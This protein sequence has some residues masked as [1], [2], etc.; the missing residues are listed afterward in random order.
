MAKATPLVLIILDGWGISNRRED[1]AIALAR[2]LY[3]ESLIK[4][5][6]LT[7]LEVSGE[8]VGLPMGQ[9][10]NSEV[11]HLNIGAGRIVYQELTRINKAI[12]EGQ[13][14][15]NPTLL[16][17]IRKIRK[18]TLHLICLLSDGGVHSHIDHLFAMLELAK[19]EGIAHVA[20]HAI[21][22]GRDTP[23]RSGSEYIK[24]LGR[25]CSE[26][27]FGTIATVS[28][29]YY[30][31]DRDKRWERVQKAYE[32]MVLGLG[33][34]RS[35]AREAVHSSYESNITDEFLLPV[36]IQNE[37]GQASNR[38][39]DGD[40]VIFLNFRADRARELTSAITAEDFSSFDRKEV[41]KLAC[42]LC[43]TEYDERFGL[44][45]LFPKVRLNSIMGRIM[46]DNG[47]RQF[48]IAETEKYAHV[49]YFFNGGEE[50]V[51][52]GED[53]LLIPSPRDVSTYDQKPEM[54][55]REV[56]K[57]VLDRIRAGN[58]DVI[59]MNY[60]NPDMIGHTG[61]L[62]AAIEAVTVIDDCL[63]KVIP[64]VKHAG[65]TV[66]LT[67]DHG[68]LEQMIDEKG[69]PHTAHTT[70]PVPFVLVNDGKPKLRENG[71]HADIAPT[72]LRILGIQQPEEMTGE[73]LIKS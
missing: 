9:M 60:A 46:S 21:L 8:A 26:L 10:G 14:Q 72:M 55:A 32:A 51:F 53:R 13:L 2:P 49:T 73:S 16:G 19:Q 43:M 6:P 65:G 1:N 47:L 56:T 70:N 33:V 28:G 20:I 59:I 54:S 63:Q 3:F 24:R 31:M 66:I 52:P 27:N 34:H 12:R 7:V 57:N 36:I 38:I 23:P 58:H 71:L 50:K 41:P 22:D 29:R 48:R 68:N 15:K 4:E 17:G 42:F 39:K 37:K 64:A 11:G 18:E 45:V 35:S 61:I 25:K 67:A 5:Y 44:P 62:K 30:A 40:G 69:G